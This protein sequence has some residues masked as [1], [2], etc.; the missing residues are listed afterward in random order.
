MEIA[1][2]L[3]VR[4]HNVLTREFLQCRL[5][6]CFIRVGIDI[7]VQGHLGQCRGR[8]RRFAFLLFFIGIVVVPLIAPPLALLNLILLL[9]IALSLGERLLLLLG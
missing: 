5:V 8:A 4:H 7:T 1:L 9:R 6:F 2:F 3:F